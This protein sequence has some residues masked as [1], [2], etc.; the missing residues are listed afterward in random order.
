MAKIVTAPKITPAYIYTRL[1]Y[2]GVVKIE[3]ETYKVEG[4]CGDR[5]EKWGHH[6]LDG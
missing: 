6:D 4:E 3:A 1:A 5:E 2:V